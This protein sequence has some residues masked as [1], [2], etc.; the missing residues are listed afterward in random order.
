MWHI[1]PAHRGRAIQRAS[2]TE[3][4]TYICVASFRHSYLYPLEV[5][6]QYCSGVAV[7]AISA[8]GQHGLMGFCVLPTQPFKTCALDEGHIVVFNP[9]VC[10]R[11][12]WQGPSRKGRHRGM[13]VFVLELKPP[14][15]AATVTMEVQLHIWTVSTYGKAQQVKTCAS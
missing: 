14:K 11:P 7:A 15:P 13:H 4:H 12:I 2:L 8:D 5:D 3:T 10:P 1:L 9:S 6:A